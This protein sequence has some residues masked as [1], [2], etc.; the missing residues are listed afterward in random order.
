MTQSRALPQPTIVLAD[1]HPGFRA[2]V[3]QYLEAGGR[4]VIVGECS[5]G[6]TCLDRLRAL[7]PDWAIIDLAMP[8]LTGFQILEAVRGLDLPTRT[9]ILSMHAETAYSERARQL[10]ASGF[11]AKEDALTEV[12][13]AL[14]M[15]PGTFFQSRAVGH[16]IEISL[17]SDDGALLATLTA[18][19]RRI[20]T[21]IANGLTSK[22]IARANGISPR[23]VQAH[24]RNIADKL[25]LHGPNKLIEFAVRNRRQLSGIA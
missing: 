7:R 9:I 21:Q 14:A 2:G 24:R 19:E 22:E 10:G 6:T 13:S 1:D 20:V 23:T 17:D 3:R 11:I 15:P 18:A 8:G 16:S 25:D 4:H 12:D 5:D